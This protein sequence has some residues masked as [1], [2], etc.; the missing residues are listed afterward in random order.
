MHTCFCWV[1][2]LWRQWNFNE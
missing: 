1:T 2:N